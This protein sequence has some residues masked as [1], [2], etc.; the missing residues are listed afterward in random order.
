MIYEIVGFQRVEYD[1]KDGTGHVSGVNLFV[2]KNI[3]T[4]RG[5]G[6]AVDREYVKS[7]LLPENF[8]IGTYDI[9]YAKTYSGQAYIANI[10]KV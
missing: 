7:S 9:E 6:I 5:Q 10:S 3:P 1:K 4:D 8:T 2:A